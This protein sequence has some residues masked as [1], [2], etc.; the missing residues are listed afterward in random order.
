MIGALTVFL[1]HDCIRRA[2]TLSLIAP[3]SLY[4]LL[5]ACSNVVSITWNKQC[6]DNLSTACEQTCYKLFV[7]L[8]QLVRFYACN[9][10]VM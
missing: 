9:D 5:T 1:L 8:F 4:T 2:G 10:S 7:G 3:S 6:E